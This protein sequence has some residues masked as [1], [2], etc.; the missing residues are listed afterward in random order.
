MWH[1][2][3]LETR[4]GFLILAA[5]VLYVACAYVYD[6]PVSVADWAHRLKNPVFFTF[7]VAALSLSGSGIAFQNAFRLRAEHEGSMLYTL[8]L[9][10][11]RRW[12]LGCRAALGAIQLAALIVLACA[13]M[14]AFEPSLRA[15][16]PAAAMLTY[17]GAVLCGHALFYGMGVL[18]STYL[19]ERWR[20]YASMAL[21]A[22]LLRARMASEMLPEGNLVRNGMDLLF[23]IASAHVAVSMAVC[24]GLAA[25]LVW[26]AVKR[27]EVQDF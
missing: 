1:K 2:Y 6:G 27:F 15:A 11:S 26:A 24:V 14:W 17:V 10:V 16:R 19:D 20:I 22:A 21:F 7:A 9:P 4:T 3:W 25:L 8:S 23:P 13:V 18:L 12:I 5:F